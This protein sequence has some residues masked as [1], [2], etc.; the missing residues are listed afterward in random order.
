MGELKAGDTVYGSNG[1]VKV[2]AAKPVSTEH[3]C[4]RVT[5]R[6]GTS[7]VASAGHLWFSRRSGW[8]AKYRDEVRTTEQMLDGYSYRVP[9]APIQDRPEIDLPADPYLLGLWL[10]DG[11]RGKCEFAVSDEDKDDTCA[12]LAGRGIV[13]NPRKYEGSNGGYG[14][15]AAWNVSFTKAAGFGMVDRPECAKQIGRAHV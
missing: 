10:G 2:S 6:D 1:P 11:T 12:I 13:T 9:V 15:A 14:K 3:E 5:L 7:V 8:P 4:Y